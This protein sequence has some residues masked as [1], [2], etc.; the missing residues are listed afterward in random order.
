MSFLF[1]LQFVFMV[2]L[3]V[4][5]SCIENSQEQ[6]KGTL[7]LFVGNQDECLEVDNVEGLKT[8]LKKHEQQGIVRVPRQGVRGLLHSE[9]WS[10]PPTDGRKYWGYPK[11]AKNSV[12]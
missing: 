5:V 4:S 10:K 3:V 6:G 11:S 2:F 1:V 8:E 12:K 9:A 7:C